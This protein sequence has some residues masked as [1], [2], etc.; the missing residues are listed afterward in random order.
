MQLCRFGAPFKTNPGVYVFCK[1][2]NT[3]GRWSA[4]YVGETDDFND[5]LNINLASHHRW[6]CI[7]RE[8]ATNVCVMQVNGGKTQRVAAETDLRK[9]LD[10]PCNRQ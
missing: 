7:Q 6:D 4:V 1:P 3:Q 2:A 8:K 5:R 10:P 9:S